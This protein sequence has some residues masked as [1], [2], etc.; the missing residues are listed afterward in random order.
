MNGE[1]K[2]MRVIVKEGSEG[3]ARE[4]GVGYVRDGPA[5]SHYPMVQ[6]WRFKC[7]ST[8]TFPSIEH[9][10]FQA[11]LLGVLMKALAK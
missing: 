1:K 8:S 3:K 11:L 9:Y 4:K 6:Q 2:K 10:W 7:K 5:Y